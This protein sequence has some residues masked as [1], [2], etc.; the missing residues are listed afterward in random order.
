MI[1]LSI[2]N[3]SGKLRVGLSIIIVLVLMSL[4]KELLIDIFVGRDVEPLA[5]GKF[6]VFLDPSR[7]H[8]LGTDRY[9]R[10]VLALIFVGLPNTLA[11]AAIAGGLSTLIG[12][13]VGFVSGYMGGW[14]D[15]VLRT[16]MDMFLVIPVLPLIFILTKYSSSLSIPT[17]GIIIAIFGWAFSAR[18]IRSQVLSLR[19]RPYVE[20]SKVTNLSSRQIIFGDILPNML[21]YIGMSLALS[22]SGA[23]FAL[24]GLT[25]V[26]LGPSD[27]I[28]LGSILFFAQSWGVLSLGKWAILIAPMFLLT[29]FFL[30]AALINQ[31]LEEVYNPRL[32][33]A[34]Q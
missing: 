8:L 15:A 24:V 1:L 7:D 32:R 20:L 13:V 34:S 16:I 17:L 5:Q 9:G 10:D 22:A 3:S 33:G 31:G 4:F 30:G 29:L 19:E 11:V 27:T 25:V 23:A 21:P 26:G 18:V 28:E 14:I 2:W 6:Q 12:V